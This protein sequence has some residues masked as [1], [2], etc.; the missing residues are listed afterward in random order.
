V[1]LGLAETF[2]VLVTFHL[3]AM[4]WV[5]F[6]ADT[7]RRAA[8][9]VGKIG[10]YA[11]FSTRKLYSFDK[12]AGASFLAACLV[13]GLVVELWGQRA[14][15]VGG[16]A[17]ARVG[18]VAVAAWC[19]GCVYRLLRPILQEPWS[20]PVPGFLSTGSNSCR[21]GL[22]AVLVLC[23]WLQRGRE[24]PLHIGTWPVP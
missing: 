19:L 14:W 2:P 15:P 24:H 1:P 23:E 12:T 18:S 3:V 10:A 20:L 9:I 16:R 22:I 7:I 6:R 11:S 4:A 21:V 17:W 8:L 5:F 13:V